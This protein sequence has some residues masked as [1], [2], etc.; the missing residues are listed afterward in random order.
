MTAGSGDEVAAEL[1]GRIGELAR[2]ELRI[3]LG[4][5]K[6]KMKEGGVAT[7]LAAMAVVLALYGGGLML[8]GA[9]LLLAKVLP[10]WLATLV[11]G[12][13]VSLAA[14]GA[15]MLGLARMRSAVPPV[16]EQATAET[17]EALGAALEAR[18]TGERR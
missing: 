14:A 1:G 9:V 2:R 7:G 18:N 11:V 13:V 17:A 12:M 6:R 4:E 10:E 3:A 16:P 15:G 8:R 5:T